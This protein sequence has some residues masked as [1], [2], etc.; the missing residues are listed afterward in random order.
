MH[1]QLAE[2]PDA[3]PRALAE[4]LWLGAR[5]SGASP[6]PAETA[7]LEPDLEHPHRPDHPEPPPP[8]LAVRADAVEPPRAGSVP[9][10]EAPRGMRG[11]GTVSRPP[12]LSDRRTWHRTL[13][14]LGA[15]GPV[16][17]RRLDLPA[18]LDRFARTGQ[19]LLCHRQAS[20]PRLR[21]VVVE[22]RATQL[23]PW[24]SMVKDLVDLAR[25]T[26]RWQRVQHLLLRTADSQPDGSVGLKTPSQVEQTLRA[27]PADGATV[28]LLVSDGLAPAWR[29]GGVARL[30]DAAPG[31]AL[32]AHAWGQ[33]ARR[34]DGRLARLPRTRAS[35]GLVVLPLTPAG[36]ESSRGWL[37]GRGGAHLDAVR[38]PSEAPPWWRGTRVL[39]GQAL[40]R[41]VALQVDL[42]VRQVLALAAGVPGDVDLELLQALGADGSL[43][44]ERVERRHLGQ[45]LASGL[46]RRV[47]GSTGVVVRF[48]GDGE[49]EEGRAVALA[50][51]DRTRAEA[52]LHALLRHLGSDRAA[53]LGIPFALLVELAGHRSAGLQDTSPAPGAKQALRAL[54]RLT[55]R[56]NER[57]RAFL[58]EDEPV[59]PSGPAAPTVRLVFERDADRVWKERL[60]T[61][62]ARRGIRVLTT[63]LGRR[64]PRDDVPVV[65]AFASTAPREPGGVGSP[66]GPA[67]W[68]ERVRGEPTPWAWAAPDEERAWACADVGCGPA[69]DVSTEVGLEGLATAL[70]DGVRLAPQARLAGRALLQVRLTEQRDTEV[71]QGEVDGE[72]HTLRVLTSQ[73]ERLAAHGGGAGELTVVRALQEQRGG[74]L[75]WQA[76]EPGL[77]AL[78]PVPLP[79]LPAAL[80]GLVAAFREDSCV[81]ADALLFR[82]DTLVRLPSLSP[83]SGG[84]APELRR[85][86]S[87]LAGPVMSRSAWDVEAAGLG[88]LRRWMEGAPAASLS[89]ALS[90]L[91]RAAQWQPL[92]PPLVPIPA[93]TFWMG[94]AE[95]EGYGHE[96]PRHQVRL[97]RPYA[98]G[99]TPVTQAQWGAVVERALAAPWASE[100]AGLA[101]L[102]PH[103]SSHTEGPDAPQRPVEQVSW[104]D[105]VTWC[106]ALSRLVG[107]QPA[108][109]RTGDDITWNHEADG[110]RLPTEA[111][112]EHACRAGAETRWWCGDDEAGLAEVAWYDANANGT[113]HPVATKPANPWGLHDAHG[114][115]W[116]WCWDWFDSNAY[117]SHAPEDPTGPPHGGSRVLRGGSGWLTANGCRSAY[118]NLWHPSYRNWDQGFRV[119]LS[120]PPSM[121]PRS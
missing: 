116:E 89:E 80:A 26:G 87:V 47:P 75:P 94:S 45:A 56:E 66:P 25:S 33:D 34:L 83:G 69:W 37:V 103:P 106:N 107:R 113:T 54:V 82:G 8:P 50:W 115:V 120:P 9:P 24:R 36:L 31:P 30:V 118:R 16:G 98:M 17:V 95:G 86:V 96:H 74:D 10:S 76:F 48:H 84:G 97:T 2:A 19:L 57:V 67:R 78:A 105:V 117:A 32:W 110:F 22:D 12:P 49:D 43:V 109:R 68:P 5:V 15:M 71:W 99:V 55:R 63:S 44:T 61:G 79:A 23:G 38:L 42:A 59:G 1:R 11:T 62:L 85:A 35:E 6:E 64:V 81:S 29:D 70:R 53:R 101:D 51:L 88:D 72:A 114:N 46:L 73:G 119:V 27:E 100:E 93:G 112:W 90:S 58:E 14:R 40:G 111:E 13:H 91:V 28:L 21:L 18:T 108:Y 104:L 39:D 52:L 92:V 4:W 102:T 121:E 41:R 20:A 65:A 60:R 3:D 77:R 7:P